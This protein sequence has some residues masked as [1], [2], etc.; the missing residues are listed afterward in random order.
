[1]SVQDSILKGDGSRFIYYTEQIRIK[2]IELIEVQDGHK[3]FKYV[4]KK[5]NNR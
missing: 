4:D 5:N 1:M 3:N 2:N